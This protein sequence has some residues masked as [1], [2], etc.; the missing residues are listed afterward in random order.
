MS[1][2]LDVRS[3][4]TALTCIA[5]TIGAPQISLPLGEVDGLPVGL[6]II[7]DRGSDE[8]LIKFAADI[9]ESMAS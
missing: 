8:A 6:S 7:G 9:A 4:N 1:D 5:G 3:R 2:R